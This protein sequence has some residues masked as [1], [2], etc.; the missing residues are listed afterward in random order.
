MNFSRPDL[1]SGKKTD[2]MMIL[3]FNKKLLPFSFFVLLSTFC[4][5]FYL[6]SGSG[7]R[8]LKP[9][10]GKNTRSETLLSANN[11]NSV[12]RHGKFFRSVSS[13]LFGTSLRLDFENSS[14]RF[15]KVLANNERFEDD[16][17]SLPDVFKW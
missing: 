14:Y 3:I 10:P 6:V 2:G 7:I 8:V 9:D 16:F 12:K 5:L 4:T 15:F 17:E 11:L 1:D 13:F